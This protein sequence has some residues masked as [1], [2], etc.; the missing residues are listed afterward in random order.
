MLCPVYFV[1]LLPVA[2]VSITIIRLTI[3]DGS[4]MV[5]IAPTVD[6][7]VTGRASASQQMSHEKAR[8]NPEPKLPGDGMIVQMSRELMCRRA[9]I[10]SLE[11]V[12]MYL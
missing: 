10:T 2:F 11:V 3:A 7:E 12:L 4:R 9:L 1:T 5:V 8:E 6:E